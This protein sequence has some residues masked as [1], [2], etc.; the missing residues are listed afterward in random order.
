MTENFENKILTTGLPKFG[1]IGEVS[2]PMQ[3]NIEFRLQAGNLGVPYALRTD[4]PF[5]GTKTTRGKLEPEEMHET[6]S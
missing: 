4:L 2:C 5:P 1:V 3:S 6:L